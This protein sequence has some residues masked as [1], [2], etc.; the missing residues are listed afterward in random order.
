M[1]K[2][3]DEIRKRIVDIEIQKEGYKPESYNPLR[4]PLGHGNCQ[5]AQTNLEWVLKLLEDCQRESVDKRSDKQETSA[6]A[7]IK[8]L[9]GQIEKERNEAV[10]EC[11]HTM[12]NTA[13]W[14]S[15]ENPFRIISELEKLKTHP[16]R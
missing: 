6:N 4:M 16:K 15:V 9:E 13:E 7:R 5:V 1:E 8:E 12:T 10:Q 11:I 2:I 14:L 3:I